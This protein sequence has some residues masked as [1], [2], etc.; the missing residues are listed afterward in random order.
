MLRIDRNEAAQKPQHANSGLDTDD[1]L[2][3]R[4]ELVSLAFK[5]GHQ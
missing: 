4:R 5:K 1:F 3:L 2:I